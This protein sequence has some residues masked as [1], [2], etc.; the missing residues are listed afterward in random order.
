MQDEDEED[1]WWDVVVVKPHYTVKTC[2]VRMEDEMACVCEGK[3]KKLKKKKTIYKYLTNM[4]VPGA[5]LRRPEEEPE[6]AIVLHL[7]PPGVIDDDSSD[8]VLS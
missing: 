1:V 3:H 2:T 6:E 5:R 8:Q 7:G 4:K